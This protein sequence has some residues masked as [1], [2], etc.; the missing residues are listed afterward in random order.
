MPTK[1][2]F[3]CRIGIHKWGRVHPAVYPS[4]EAERLAVASKP[5]MRACQCC[6]QDQYLDKHCLGLNPPTYT[7]TWRNVED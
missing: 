6:D 3:L 7:S 1:K 2:R 5:A 4:P